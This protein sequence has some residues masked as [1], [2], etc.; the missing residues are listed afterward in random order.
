LEY[1]KNYKNNYW[2][3]KK[4]MTV[5]RT[6]TRPEKFSVNRLSAHFFF[7]NQ[8]MSG[9]DVL[10]KVKEVKKEGCA[11]TFSHFGLLTKKF[12]TSTRVF[13]RNREWVTILASVSGIRSNFVSGTLLA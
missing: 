3:I 10:Q 4:I 5:F 1:K 7:L 13:S 6:L 2:N 11:A 8:A 9:G 12:I